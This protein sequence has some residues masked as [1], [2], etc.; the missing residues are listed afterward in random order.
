M[1]GACS[2]LVLTLTALNALSI[3]DNEGL[4]SGASGVSTHPYRNATSNITTDAETVVCCCTG[5]SQHGFTGSTDD[6]FVEKPVRGEGVNG[7]DYRS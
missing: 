4:R 6:L 1:L 3:A 7:T 2:A 5:I